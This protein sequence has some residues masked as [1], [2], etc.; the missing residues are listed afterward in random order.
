MTGLSEQEFYNKYPDQQS[1]MMEYGGMVEEYKKGG[2]IQKATASIKKRGTE[3]KCTPMSK[4]GCTGRALALAKTFHKMAAKRKKKE[5]GGYVDMYADGG[6]LPEGILRSR[7]EA[8][9]SPTEAQN[10]INNYAEG[11]V[12]DVY[13]LMGMP[14]PYM[15]GMGGDTNISSVSNQYTGPQGNIFENAITD[16]TG[17]RQY[18]R[19]ATPGSLVQYAGDANQGQ[20]SV[21]GQYIKDPF[22]QNFLHQKAGYKA[23]GYAMG[24]QV[25]C[26]ECYKKDITFA[27]GGIVGNPTEINVER[28]ELLTDPKGKIVTEYKG[29]GMVPH[30]E[31]G[32]DDRGTVPAQ[33]G[34]FVV[35]KAMAPKYKAAMKNNDKLY[36][37][38]IRNNIA[39]RKEKKEAKE[40]AEASAAMNRMM[41]KYGGTIKRMYAKGGMINKYDGGSWTGINNFLQGFGSNLSGS[42]TTLEPAA[43]EQ[44]PGAT[45]LPFTGTTPS[46]LNPNNFLN[47][48]PANN[49][50]QPP[51]R[52]NLWNG[53]DLTDINN[54]FKTTKTPYNFKE[55]ASKSIPW[56][57]AGSQVIEP[58]LQKPFSMKSQDYETPAD[59]KWREL[60]GEAGRRDLE[61]AYAG[62]KY[63][64][65]NIGGSNALAALTSGSNNY[66]GQVAKYNE[67]LENLNRQG[68]TGIDAQNKAI[69]Q[70]NM[71]QRMQIGMFNEQNRAAR[72]NAIRQGLMNTAAT[73]YNQDT[74]NMAKQGLSAAY[75]SYNFPWNKTKKG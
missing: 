12:V 3:G 4:P 62:A 68:Q 37:D 2:W 19:Q 5:E 21:N 43:I 8:H 75:P 22:M 34:M 65:R 56:I 72:R 25:N 67:N 71:N 38:A 18:N 39:F 53:D 31:E 74:S 36:A 73:Y 20:V 15:Y 59:L 49:L 45:G 52:Y 13:Q 7:L 23:S 32:M 50:S 57:V 27:M 51:G 26:P 64:M 66:Y 40:E 47:L 6:K 41:A 29:G 24:G 30:P 42:I 9:M 17:F 55:A 48:D 35:T 16:D 28:G 1:F 63:A 70:A 11:G 58:L 61:K 10:Y 54:P 14:T 69:Q 46:H 60:T 33:E 44:G